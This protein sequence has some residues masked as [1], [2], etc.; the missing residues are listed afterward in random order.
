MVQVNSS[1]ALPF[2]DTKYEVVVR[3]GEKEIKTGAPSFN[4]GRYNRYNFKTTPEQAE[5]KAPYLDAF[6]LGQ[7][8]IY[9]R[10]K[11]T[12]KGEQNVCYYRSS[13]RDFIDMD[14]KIKWLEFQPDLSLGAVT[15]S[16]MAGLVGI[17]ISIHDVTANG[18]AD[19]KQ[20]IWGQ[21]V[22]RRPGNL[23]A[24]AYIY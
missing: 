18:P 13:V 17:R 21:R 15:E 11:S 10:G 19:W 1:I 12:L 8:F 7:V 2:P 3:I 5:Y 14:P 22:P 6:D 9:L 4:K 24:R 16:H 23:K 20:G